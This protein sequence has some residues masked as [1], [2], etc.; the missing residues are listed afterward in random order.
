MA[1]G[2]AATDDLLKADKASGEAGAVLTSEG[3][4]LSVLTS[5]LKG[6]VLTSEARQG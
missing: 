5:P 2:D 6:D 3:V 1:L 4:S